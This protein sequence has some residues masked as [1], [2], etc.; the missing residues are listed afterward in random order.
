MQTGRI[1]STGKAFYV[2]YRVAENGERV[3]RSQFLCFKDDKYYEV[4]GEPCKAVKLLRDEF[5]LTINKQDGKGNQQNVRIVDFWEATYLPYAKENLRPS[6]LSGYEQIWNQHLKDHFADL[7]LREYRTHIGS[8]FLTSLTK[9]QGRRTIAHV[10]SLASGVFSHAVN[11]GL[12]ESNVWHDVKVLAKMKAVENTPHYTLEEIEDIISALVDHVECQLIMALAFFLGLRPGEI[13]GLQWGD[14]D[15]QWLH[16]RRAVVRRKVG[17][18]KTPE[19]VASLPLIQPVKGLLQLWRTRCAVDGNVNTSGW[20][21]ENRSGNPADL[22]DIIK[23][24]IK[25]ALEA[26]GIEWK[27]L[28]AGRRGA[29]TVLTA[30]TGSAIAAQQILRHKN[31]AVTEGF[32]V[33]EMPEEGFKGMKLLETKALAARNGEEA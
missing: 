2:Q 1:Y 23:R 8:Q 24:V 22:K 14:V 3:Q 6:T 30:L 27:T 17:E 12:L 19:S 5:M 11:V 33:K 31:L 28:Y 20:I 26:K 21:F 29:G 4:K 18:T 16:I 9:K 7:T 32:Y 10:R 15:E 13:S 25:P